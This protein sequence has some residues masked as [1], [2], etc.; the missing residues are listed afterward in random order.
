VETLE[1]RVS[2]QDKINAELRDALKAQ[3]A[4]IEKVS[5]QMQA[6]SRAPQL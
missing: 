4:Q 5:A 6:S 1:T 3:A 2:A